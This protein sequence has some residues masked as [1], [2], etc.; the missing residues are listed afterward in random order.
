LIKNTN[1]RIQKTAE[2]VKKIADNLNDNSWSSFFSQPLFISSAL[3][4]LAGGVYFLFKKSNSESSISNNLP[5]E[6][7][8]NEISSVVDDVLEEQKNLRNSISGS[9]QNLPVQN[10]SPS[11]HYFTSQW[12]SFFFGTGFGGSLARFW[13]IIKRWKKL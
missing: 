3:L 10:N 7:S 8:N 11:P 9:S 5:N 4:L 12:V 2:D 6:G 1:E 13:N